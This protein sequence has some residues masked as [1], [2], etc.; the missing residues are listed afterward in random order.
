M[1]HYRKILV[2]LGILFLLTTSCQAQ[3]LKSY[4]DYKL[5]QRYEIKKFEG[6]LLMSN[7]PEDVRKPGILYRGNICGKGRLLYHHVNVSNQQNLRLV[8]EIV[9]EEEFPQLVRVIKPTTEGPSYQFLKTGQTI[10]KNYFESTRD[11]FYYLEPKEKWSLYDSEEKIWKV[12]TLLSGMMDIETTGQVAVTYKVI[13]E[14]SQ[15]E[16]KLIPL[17]RDLAPRG[18]FGI[19]A[20]TYHI[21]IPKTPGYY[22]YLLG[23]TKEWE[24]GIDELTGENVLNQGN[25]G[26]MEHIQ[27]LA[28]ADTIAILCPRGG[29]FR[30][31]VRWQDGQICLVERR[32]SFKREKEC[33]EIGK[34]KKGEIR[35]LD[36]MLPNGS[37]APVLL[38]FWVK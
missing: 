13:T 35:Q 9:N 4:V 16:K 38:G 1:V 21:E 19:L 30:G 14:N 12:G 25:Y 17:I 10:L 2:W 37:A 31:I 5:I 7:S 6:T 15:Y 8:I 18:S 29:V 24:K 11:E 28:Q 33:I 26:I 32:H 23:T 22:Y 20:R 27:I 34:F 3:L 36:Y